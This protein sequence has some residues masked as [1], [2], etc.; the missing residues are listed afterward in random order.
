MAT[1]VL[2][3][4][5]L[6][7]F[8]EDTEV[9][10]HWSSFDSNGASITRSTNGTIK[11]RRDDGTDCTGTSVTDTEDTPDTG[12][13]ECKINTGDNSNFAIGYDYTVW[14]DGATIDSQTVNSTLAC[15][16]IQNR[17]V[18]I[19]RISGDTTAANNLEATYDG[20]GYE[21]D[22]APAQQ[23]QIRRIAVTGSAINT[24][25]ESYVL[26]TGTQSANTY[27]ATIPLDGVRHEHTDSGG[28]MDLY[29]QFSI[30]GDGV[31]TSFRM[32]G[33]I[34]GNGDNI[35]VYAYDWEGTSWDQIGILEGTALNVD[36]NSTYILYTNHVGTGVNIGKVRIRFYAASGLSSATLRIDQCYVSYSVVSRSVG[37]SIG[38]IWVD[39]NGS[40]TNSESYIDGTADNPVS[41]WATALTLSG[42]LNINKFEIASGSL[43]TLS[44]NSD[45]YTILGTEYELDLGG[46]SI[47]GGHIREATVTG[48]GTVS[49]GEIHFVD[50]HVDGCTLGKSHFTNCGFYD[51]IVFSDAA[52]YIFENCYNNATGDPP[53]F[54]FGSSVGDTTAAFRNWSGGL[55]IKNLGVSGT[56]KVTFIGNGTLIIDSSCVGGT[57]GIHGSV[58]IVDNVSG[59]FESVGTL[60]DDTRY[61]IDQIRDSVVDDE[62][63]ID[64]SALNALSA[65]TPGTTL[66]DADDVSTISSAIAALNDVS[67]A[68]IT[69]E[70]YDAL[71]TDTIAELSQAAPSATPT[72]VNALMLL[73]MELRNARTQTVTESAIYND[74]GT[75]IAKATTDF[76]GVTT[77]KSKYGSGA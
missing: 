74:A 33:R 55:V 77:T 25:A 72:I 2:D 24:F 54:D 42:N 1:K 68:E 64:G 52:L 75:K 8:V 62:T 20:T 51:D 31:P 63:K 19:G 56:D 76:D 37:Y 21:N 18:D 6:G 7:D 71:R 67:L 16:S 22:Y 59:G 14:L 50:C 53:S 11:V 30:G 38:A 41:T 70:I 69:T 58:D 29:Y 15:F 27:T 39:T 48:T 12:I 46:Q 32:T 43:V 23:S 10:F 28:V 35:G 17:V 34:N 9:V 36:S 49:S 61:H 60:N 45:G 13:H 73:Y 26:T 44:G 5:Y 3:V 4:G 66:A 57:I 65:L 40:N 47:N